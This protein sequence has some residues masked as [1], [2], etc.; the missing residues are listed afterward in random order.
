M[1]Q[2]GSQERDRG[3]Q[4]CHSRR[5]THRWA[6]R[7]APLLTFSHFL[8][9]FRWIYH[10]SGPPFFFFSSEELHS[11]N[12]ALSNSSWPIPPICPRVKTATRCCLTLLK[13]TSR[14]SQPMATLGPQMFRSLFFSKVTRA[15]RPA[16]AF[17]GEGRNC[18]KAYPQKWKSFRLHFKLDF[19]SGTTTMAPTQ[20]LLPTGRKKGWFW[21]L[22]SLSAWI[23]L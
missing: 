13:R 15:R 12:P 7:W 3:D 22:E 23:H 5:W 20:S 1:F 10:L 17:R 6:P 9:H 11:H 8:P 16:G 4:A 2:G 14:K 18:R 19:I 21:L